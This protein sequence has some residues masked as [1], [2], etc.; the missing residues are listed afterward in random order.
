[1]QDNYPAGDIYGLTHEGIF[2]Q[3]REKNIQYHFG[4]ITKHTDIMLEKF[5]TSYR[6]S[7]MQFDIKDVD[8]ISKSVVRAVRESV[9]TSSKRA[10]TTSMAENG[11][12]LKVGVFK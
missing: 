11:E 3:I 12:T 2:A 6:D 10:T 9:W 7:I 1:M 4:K 8:L 5:V